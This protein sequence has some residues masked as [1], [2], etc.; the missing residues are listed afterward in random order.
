VLDVDMSNV[1]AQRKETVMIQSRFNIHEEVYV[2]QE[3]KVVKCRIEKIIV[4]KTIDAERLEYIVV[5]LNIDKQEK[6]R[7]K[8]FSEAYIVKTLEEAKASALI[9]WENI[10]KRVKSQLEALKDDS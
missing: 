2:V 9:N 8:S 7:E 3:Y 6:T 1:Y 10:Y 5:P 4:C